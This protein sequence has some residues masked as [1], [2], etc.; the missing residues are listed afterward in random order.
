LKS[1]VC[2]Y[3]AGWAMLGEHI[4]DLKDGRTYRHFIDTIRHLEDLFEVRP[5]VIAADM[6]PLYLSSDYAARRARGELAGC[7]PARLIRV[8]HHHAH[9]SACLAENDHAGQ[10]LAI[11]ADGVGYGDDGAVWG[12]EVFRC[13]LACY[14]RLAH[15]RYT[16]LPGGDKAAEETF[17]P[18]LAGLY[19]ALGD[20]CLRHPI[21]TRLGADLDTIQQTLDLLRAGVNCPQSSSLGRWFDAAAALAG[22]ARANRF[23]GQAPMMLEAAN[24]PGVEDAYDFAIDDQATP[25]LID[26]RPTVLALADD[27]VSGTPPAELAAKF[28][29]TV[30]A[31]LHASASLARDRTGLSVLALSGGCF[32]NR[33][34]LARLVRLLQAD[35]FTVLTHRAVPT[36]DACIALGQ[37]VSAAA[38]IAAEARVHV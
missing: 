5:E 21:I 16:R 30:A 26:L 4:G 9:A 29:N 12:C 2:L 10:A 25:M 36:N 34:L 31:F 28:H 3:R 8:Q 32:M 22:L 27:V 13:D 37:A 19:D 38:R 7:P 18:A 23:E 17:R 35:A 15:L 33:Y 24:A 6:H 14:Q 11:V 1:A 20:D